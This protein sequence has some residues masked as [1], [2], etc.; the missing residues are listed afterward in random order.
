MTV[1]TIQSIILSAVLLT[2]AAAGCLRMRDLHG[3]SLHGG[4][5]ENSN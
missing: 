5:E 4:E 3:R 2:G 1:K